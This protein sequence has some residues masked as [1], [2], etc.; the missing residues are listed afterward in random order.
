M[1]LRDAIYRRIGKRMT[2][3]II[4]LTAG[5]EWG[6]QWPFAMRQRL[7]DLAVTQRQQQREQTYDKA[8]ASPGCD[9]I[10]TSN[11]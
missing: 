5:L 8:T 4:G 7:I 6:R 9:V 2:S 10:I 1:P 11:Y 3:I